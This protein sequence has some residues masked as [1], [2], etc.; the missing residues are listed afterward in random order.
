MRLDEFRRINLKV[1]QN[2]NIIYEGE[3]ENIP[4]ELK[5]L[6]TQEIKIQPGLAEVIL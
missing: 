4:E 2:E 3:A 5:N 6:Q 1:I